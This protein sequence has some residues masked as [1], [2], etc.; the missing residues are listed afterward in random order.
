[1]AVILGSDWSPTGDT[2]DSA[3]ADIVDVCMLFVLGVKCCQVSYYDV[4]Y[5][6]IVVF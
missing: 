6:V 4:I 2:E 5:D 3:D 1:M